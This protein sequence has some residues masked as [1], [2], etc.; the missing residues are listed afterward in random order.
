MD[1]QMNPN[2]FSFSRVIIRLWI[3]NGIVLNFE[4]IGRRKQGKCEENIHIPGTLSW[5]RRSDA[6]HR[7]K[8][9][10]VCL[11]FVVCQKFDSLLRKMSTTWADESARCCWQTHL[12]FFFFSRKN[13]D[14]G[15]TTHNL[16][17]LVSSGTWVKQIGLT[18]TYFPLN[19]SWERK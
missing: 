9:A 14:T 3:V 11:H 19:L 6:Q 4:Y 10:L 17:V 2:H 16:S 5:R 18:Y 15:L 1:K 12:T 13:L 8:R 7:D